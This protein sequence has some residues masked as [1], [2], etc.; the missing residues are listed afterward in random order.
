MAQELTIETQLKALGLEKEPNIVLKIDGFDDIWGAVQVER[1]PTYGDFG[2]LYGQSN[3]FYGGL[4]P[5]PNARDYLSLKGTTTRITQQLELDQGG[6]G[7]IQALSISLLDTQGELTEK[8]APGNIVD[9]VLSRSATVYFLFQDTAFPDDAIVLFNGIVDQITFGPGVAIIR[10]AHPDQLKRQEI[11]TEITHELDGAIDDTETTITLS[12]TTGM[13]APVADF[14]TYIVIN[15]EIIKYTG[16]SGNDL[17]GCVRGQLNT[18]ADSHADEDSTKTFY[19]LHGNCIDIALKIMLSQGDEFIFLGAWKRSKNSGLVAPA[20]RDIF[21]FSGIR[22]SSDFG[23]VVGDEI[24]VSPGFPPSFPPVYSAILEITETTEGTFVRV[25]GDIGKIPFVSNIKSKYNLWPIG[26]GL[27]PSQVDIAEHERVNSLFSSSFPMMDLYIK[28]GVTGNDFIEKDLMK[29][30][31]LYSIPRKGRSSIGLTLPP[32]A[33]AQ[34]QVIDHT[35]VINPT[36]L[37]ITR[38]I[39]DNFYNSVVYSYNEDSLEDKFLSGEIVIDANSLDRIKAKNRP[40]KIEARGFRRGGG[41]EPLIRRQAER[42]LDRYK[43]AAESIRGI[44]VTL[45]VGF[46]IDITDTVIFGSPELQISDG[47]NGTRS[48]TPRVMEVVNKTFDISGKVTIDL[49]DTSFSSLG[50]YGVISPS[51]YVSSYAS[52]LL[53]L[54][55]SFTTTGG[56]QIKWSD[57]IGELLNIHSQDYSVEIS[58]RLVGL[59]GGQPNGIIITDPSAPILEDYLVDIANYDVAEGKTKAIHCFFTPEVTIASG[60]NSTLFT[61]YDSSDLF[62]GAV[63][64][65]HSLDFSNQSPD[66][67]II[68]IVGT[69]IETGDLGF[70]PADGDVINLVGFKEDEGLPY[71]IL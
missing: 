48:F 29:P 53:I 21:L 44:Q 46:N 36:Q 32:L 22:L 60:T 31:A 16:I 43:F 11:F 25:A 65:V 14:E 63:I 8:F 3:L 47:K 41:T 1:I 55:R 7:S 49:L 18:I 34:T 6:A 58:V 39:N 52:N 13:V 51:S 45:G 12:S 35:N 67:R 15:D 28:S 50:R 2:L 59:A 54:K 40:L 57:Y 68:S 19:R 23:V 62:V 42:I 4:V 64:E 37:K 5:D 66:V 70:T 61:V 33:E 20:A 38:S 71:R 69:T 27:K 30:N 10:V 17:T 24:L 26:L 9:D 56:E